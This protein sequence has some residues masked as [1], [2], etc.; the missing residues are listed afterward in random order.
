MSKNSLIQIVNYI[1]RRSSEAVEKLARASRLASPVSHRTIACLSS[2][3]GILLYLFFPGKRRKDSLSSI[4]CFNLFDTNVAKLYRLHLHLVEIQSQCML[5]HLQMWSCV[6]PRW[7]WGLQFQFQY[8]C[9]P[10]VASLGSICCCFF[11][12]SFLQYVAKHVFSLL[13]FCGCSTHA[14][15]HPFCHK[16]SFTV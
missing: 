6:K 4:V 16:H 10:P 5:D 7:E 1:A 3:S 14:A 12:P 8:M 2:P 11:P 15:S 9:L 13:K